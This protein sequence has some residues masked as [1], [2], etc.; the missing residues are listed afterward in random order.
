VNEEEGKALAERA[1]RAVERLA[2][3]ITAQA[4]AIEHFSCV[5]QAQQPRPYPATT[6]GTIGVNL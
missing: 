1:L 5:L 3:A 4:R 6:G 2:E